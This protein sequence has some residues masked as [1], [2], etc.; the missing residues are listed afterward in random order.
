M[1]GALLH[2]GVGHVWLAIVCV[3]Q[4]M[5]IGW[6]VGKAAVVEGGLVYIVV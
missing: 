2:D 5:S 3:F 1:F 4:Y 6:S